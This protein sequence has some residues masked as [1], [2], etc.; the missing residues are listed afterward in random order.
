MNIAYIRTMSSV[1]EQRNNILKYAYSKGVLI[2][3][4]LLDDSEAIALKERTSFVDFMHSLK[5]GDTLFIDSCHYLSQEIEDIIKIFDCI[6]S[7]EVVAVI[8]K[9]DFRVDSNAKAEDILKILLANS[10]AHDAK[11]IT[12]GRP[13]GSI[14]KSKFDVFRDE[15]ITLLKKDYNITKIAKTLAVSRTSLRDYI[16]SRNLKDIALIELSQAKVEFQSEAIPKSKCTLKNKRS[17]D[18][19]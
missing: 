15:I 8:C 7:R 14:S 5:K 17:L 6:L 12:L 18:V 16:E 4:D 19:D 1:V 2:D 3:R 11:E 13:K 10:T 9:Y